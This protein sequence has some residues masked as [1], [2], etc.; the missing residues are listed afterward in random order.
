MFCT[1]R[2]FCQENQYIQMYFASG[3]LLFVS[4]KTHN[5]YRSFIN[6]NY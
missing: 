3:L 1:D 2:T 4:F 6:L 5:K